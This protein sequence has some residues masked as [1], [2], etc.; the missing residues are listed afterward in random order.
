M[1]GT[2]N[3]VM[4]IGNL[5]TDP[6]IRRFS[7]G[8]AIARLAVATSETYTNREGQRVSNTEWHTVILRKG[9]ADIAEKY[10]HKGDKVFIEGRIRTRKWEENGQPRYTT[11]VQADSMTMLSPKKQEDG[12]QPVSYAPVAD[13]HSSDS[14]TS[15]QSNSPSAGHVHEADDDDLPF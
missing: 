3:K 8:S 13:P 11:E 4:L 9:L 1:A 12:V 15:D 6:E 10:L 2:L 7:D 14:D 5:G